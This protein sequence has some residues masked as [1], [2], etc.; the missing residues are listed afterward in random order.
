MDCNEI[1]LGILV[2]LCSIVSIVV[3]FYLTKRKEIKFK[4]REEKIKVYLEFINALFDNEKVGFEPAVN[5]I[6]FI[7]TPD[8]VNILNDLAK[9]FLKKREGI[10]DFDA[11]SQTLIRALFIEIR[12]DIYGYENEEHTFPEEPIVFNY[13]SLEKR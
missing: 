13:N 3:G 10:V 1:V 5:K 6:F 12:K 8:V 4:E 9:L 11:K 7:G 2:P